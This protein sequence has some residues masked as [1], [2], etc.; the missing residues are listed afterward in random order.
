MIQ[1]NSL[2]RIIGQTKINKNKFNLTSH[3]H[4]SKLTLGTV[5]L[6]MNYGIANKIGMPNADAICDIL[7]AALHGGINIIDTSIDYGNSEKIIGEFIKSK[8]KND[9][10]IVTKFNLVNNKS[11]NLNQ[12]RKEIYE[13]VNSS[14]STLG[15]DKIPVYLFH[16]GKGQ[17]MESYAEPV[18]LVLSELKKDGLIS[19]GGVS[20]FNP[21]DVHI[22][23]ENQEFQAVQIPI[24]VFDQRLIVD[25]TLAKM[26]ER[27]K[28]VFARSVYLQGLFFLNPAG[29]TGNL[30]S[31]FPYLQ[32]IKTLSDEVGMTIHE[33]CF[34]FVRDLCG[35][36][37]MVVGAEN[38]TQVNDNI[39]L[40]DAPALS[41]E[42]R[43]KISNIFK[44]VPK[45]I[46]TPA[47][48]KK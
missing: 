20:F 21:D 12:I 15:I 2:G 17:D 38:V 8:K 5:Q 1:L 13:Q 14:I 18:S 16:Q 33:M 7:V 47:L 48:W 29:L 37:S 26:K 6:G 22:I 41:P 3:L 11:I 35:I 30:I 32:K 19:V 23:L 24:N 10:N 25:G 34:S 42:F 31:A 45:T 28:I 9:L 46:I 39:K 27:N 40:L 36:S 44:D 4:I 43:S